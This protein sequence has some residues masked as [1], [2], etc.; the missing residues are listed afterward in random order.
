MNIRIAAATSLADAKGIAKVHVN[1]WRT[2]YTGIVPDD[3]LDQLSYQGW[4]QLWSDILSKG[5]V[6]VA[7][8]DKGEIVGFSSGGIERSGKYEDFDGELYAIYLLKEYQGQGI[9][10]QL[11]KAVVD[12]LKKDQYRSMTVLVVEENDSRFF[13]EA[14][15]GKK[16]DRI[17]IEIGGK[18]L[19]ELVYGWKDINELF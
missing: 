14:L 3:Y 12:D 18:K 1:S 11:F 13:Y 16:I 4:Q 7:E 2:T 8:N 6:F 9:G 10:T 17:E 15:G 19:Y 5:K